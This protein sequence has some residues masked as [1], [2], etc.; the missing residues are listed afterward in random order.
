MQKIFNGILLI[1][2]L[3][4]VTLFA[5]KTLK[6]P[7][8]SKASVTNTLAT[9]D[10]ATNQNLA[11]T[12]SSE[13]E[14]N[15]KIHDYILAHPEVLIESIESMQRKKAEDSNKQAADYLLQNRS[16]I[17]DDG[18]PPMFGKKD[19]D[20]TIVVFY[21]YNCSF[22]KQANEITN[23]ILA[24][25][26]GVKIILRPLPILGGTSMYAT[27]I[28]LAIHKISEEKFP[29]IHNEMMKMKPI[30]EEGVKALLAANNIDYTIVENE[31]SSFDIKQLIAKNFDLAKSLGIKGAPSYV[32]NGIFIPGLI[33]KERF[34]A[35]IGELRQIAAQTQN[36]ET[37]KPN[38][39]LDDPETKDDKDTPK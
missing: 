29:L 19:S 6:T 13:E 38:N 31:L 14:L 3:V 24:N 7:E 22:C 8:V 28:A 25:D 32:V 12:K 37:T 27:K 1:I 34:T 20:I 33:D 39:G 2:F 10:K 36:V 30:T 9:D 26:Q 23:E 5:Y 21:D 11:E 16:S 17:E 35:I 4:L 15:N 18:T